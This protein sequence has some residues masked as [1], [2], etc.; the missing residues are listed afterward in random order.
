LVGI[1]SCSWFEQQ[2]L[3]NN[4]L[5]AL[6]RGVLCFVDNQKKLQYALQFKVGFGSGE[7]W[8]CP[9]GKNSKKEYYHA[10]V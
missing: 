2:R 10:N 9:V 5:R 3:D 1:Q 4:T 7:E 6:P 8:L